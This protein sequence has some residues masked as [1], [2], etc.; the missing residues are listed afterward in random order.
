MNLYGA[1]EYIHENLHLS[2]GSCSSRYLKRSSP[3]YKLQ[4]LLF[5]P[6]CSVWRSTFKRLEYNY[7]SEL[8]ILRQCRPNTPGYRSRGSGFDSRRYQIFWVVGPEWGPLSLVRITEELL[9][10]KSSGSGSRELRL[11]VVG[12]RC[13]DHATPSIRNIWH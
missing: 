13:A 3:E 6:I 2:Q 8:R 7:F 12:I 9:E 4:A 10:W 5:E 1:N 11:T